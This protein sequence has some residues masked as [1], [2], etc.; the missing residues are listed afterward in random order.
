MSFLPSS[1]GSQLMSEAQFDAAWDVIPDSP[2]KRAAKAALAG[3][4]YRPRPKDLDTVAPEITSPNISGPYTERTVVRG[5]LRASES[6]TFFYISS[7]IAVTLDEDTGEYSFVV[8]DYEAQAHIIT[9]GAVDGFGLTGIQNNT[10]TPVS[11]AAPPVISRLSVE[12]AGTIINGRKLTGVMEWSGGGDGSYRWLD[13]QGA[14]LSA[15]NEWTPTARPDG[16]QFSLEG[17]VTPP[18][19]QAVTKVLSFTLKSSPP[20]VLEGS[21]GNLKTLLIPMSDEM[22]PDSTPDLSAIMV[23]AP[24]FGS[25]PATDIAVQSNP[26]MLR[27]LLATAFAPGELATFAYTKPSENPLRNLDGEPLESFTG[28]TILNQTARPARVVRLVMDK[29]IAYK[30]P[31]NPDRG[32]RF[33]IEVDRLEEGDEAAASVLWAL[34]ADPA[35]TLKVS[36][37]DIPFTGNQP[38][39]IPLGSLV[40]PTVER[41]PNESTVE[42]P[43]EGG[44]V[45]I[46]K[47]A[48]CV[49]AT[50]GSYGPFVVRSEGAVAALPAPVVTLR[51]WDTLTVRDF[52]DLP[53]DPATLPQPSAYTIKNPDGSVNPVLAVAHGVDGETGRH[54]VSRTVTNQIVGGQDGATETYVPPATNP[55][56]GTNGVPASGYTDAPIVNIT[57]VPVTVAPDG[58]TN[59]ISFG[60]RKLGVEVTG[61]PGK[62]VP[63]QLDMNGEYMMIGAFTIVSDSLAGT[64][65]RHGATK[66]PIFQQTHGWDDRL[67]TKGMGI[68]DSNKAMFRETRRM[69][70][71]AM[72]VPEDIA[73]FAESIGTPEGSRTAIASYYPLHCIA[74]PVSNPQNRVAPEAIRGTKPLRA[75]SVSRELDLD[76]KLA[77]LPALPIP[78][79]KI[80]LGRVIE[81]MSRSSPVSAFTRID[82]SGSTG[83]EV[84]VPVG[85]SLDGDDAGY[86]TDLAYVWTPASY[87]ILD[88][89]TPAA[90]RKKLLGWM[91]AH[92]RDYFFHQYNDIDNIMSNG[93]GHFSSQSIPAMWALWA[94]GETE[95]LKH[96]GT[97]AKA[98]YDNT[99]QFGYL[100]PAHIARCVP[101]DDTEDNWPNVYR[102]WEVKAIGVNSSGKPTIS[103]TWGGD[104]YSGG[105][106]LIRLASTGEVLCRSAQGTNITNPPSPVTIQVDTT[107]KIKVG[108]VIYHSHAY[109]LE[110]GQAH[111]S[112]NGIGLTDR[113]ATTYTNSTGQGFGSFNPSASASYRTS[114]NFS[115]ETNAILAAAFAM[116]D[117]PFWSP[118]IDEVIQANRANFP[119]PA[120]NVQDI[121]SMR[122]KATYVWEGLYNA[123]GTRKTVYTYMDGFYDAHMQNLVGADRFNRVVGFIP[124]VN[125]PAVPVFTSGATA[126]GS[127]TAQATLAGG[128]AITYSILGGRH[129]HLF[130]I[131][132]ATGVVTPPA[133]PGTYDV[134]VGAAGPNLIEGYTRSIPKRVAFTVAVAASDV[135]LKIGVVGSSTMNAAFFNELG[136]TSDP[137]VTRSLSTSP[138]SFST[139]PGLAMRRIGKALRARY[140]R[141][142]QF[143]KCTVGGTTVAGWDTAGNEDMQTTVAAFQAVGGVDLILFQLGFNDASGGTFT[144]QAEH[145]PRLRSVLAKLRA[146]AGGHVPVIMGLSQKSASTT[147]T[148]AAHARFDA[149]YLAEDAVS[150]D[151]NN[152][153]GAQQYDQPQQDTI[154]MTDAGYGPWGDRFAANI[155]RAIDGLPIA[156]GPRMTGLVSNSTTSTTV[157]LSHAVATDFTPASGITGFEVSQDNFATVVPI[158]AAVRASASSIT[159]THA[160]LTP[161]ATLGVRFLRGG[162]PPRTAPPIDNFSTPMPMQPHPT[163]RTAIVA[164]G[165]TPAPAPTPSPPTITNL[166]ISPATAKIGQV[167]T[168]SYTLGGGA[169]DRVVTAWQR[170][171]V[172]IAGT[173]TDGPGQ[174]GQATSTHTL[175]S[176]LPWTT[177]DDLTFYVWAGNTGGSAE[178]TGTVPFEAAGTA[179]PTP[180]PTPAP[181]GTHELIS[182][183]NLNSLNSPVPPSSMFDTLLMLMEVRTP[184]AFD[185]SQW[186]QTKAFIKDADNAGSTNPLKLY[187][188]FTDGLRMLGVAGG[189]GHSDFWTASEVNQ[190][191]VIGYYMDRITGVTR[192]FFVRADGTIRE[193]TSTYAAAAAQP[194]ASVDIAT[195]FPHGLA[196]F[197]HNEPLNV[198]ASRM[199]IHYQSGAGPI[200]TLANDPTAFAGS[201]LQ[202]LVSWGEGE[203]VMAE[204]GFSGKPKLLYNL[205]TA[206]ANSSVPNLGTVPNMPL[207]P[208]LSVS[209][210]PFVAG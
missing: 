195:A 183:V 154:H 7:T 207:T 137:L 22:N 139:C 80:R 82:N 190:R 202:P 20:V 118:I 210:N 63:Y 134:I 119:G 13:A 25:Q 48:G 2:E 185:G 156:T 53:L 27:V 144:T 186:A 49:I 179:T 102:R 68:S 16:F 37:G 18:T 45:S 67:F 52:Y 33:H 76:A 180:T 187:M 78:G 50:G 17:K 86:S 71:P 23:S 175:S 51:Q 11:V 91:I 146:A 3:K 116:K 106:L 29:A 58:T 94:L 188:N 73:V 131:D 112:I 98:V 121:E 90:D 168:A 113:N 198:A 205:T 197:G 166:T 138:T 95:I 39:S 32:I 149:L 40:S 208:R 128:G 169:P 30:N 5:Q 181:A 101:H 182:N 173:I 150:K 54:F 104:H 125:P 28:Q 65:G 62:P 163:A 105:G 127:Y 157:L 201:V 164:G 172:N 14:E 83:Y 191:G 21:I 60:S 84:S 10:I 55:L 12:P 192:I 115:F 194:A 72:M 87:Y 143:V 204:L 135:P 178:K 142:I 81:A 110:D 130:T 4:A 122:F 24:S 109:S 160:A 117:E 66:N 133:A 148:T 61:Q 171:G 59:T 153:F 57:A 193:P 36:N 152:F 47:P 120:T 88:P 145:E 64:A 209:T 206:L 69:T 162:N 132:P 70:F 92:G 199:L 56:K 107:A 159:L 177:D 1:S 8:P 97:P 43:D 151:A 167:S 89:T 19:G 184:A 147:L 155:I 203:S 46:S 100:T 136:E 35:A 6:V 96:Y 176:G 103:I 123:D 44:A 126:T 165:S 99:L 114:Q 158:S 141:P 124:M 77:T 196:M 108:D 41:F 38:L 26:P 111:W 200:G 189:I 93:G 74:A 140:N 79:R 75:R 85:F 161:G 34:G 129:G 31:A 42:A 15:T 174:L 9:F 170:N